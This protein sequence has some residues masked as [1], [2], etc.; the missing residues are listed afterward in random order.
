MATD[1]KPTFLQKLEEKLKVEFKSTLPTRWEVAQL[2]KRRGYCRTS[3]SVGDW[4]RI[5]E[6]FHA[7]PAIY[8]DMWHCIAML[9]LVVCGCV[10]TSN[11]TATLIAKRSR[12]SKLNSRNRSGRQLKAASVSNCERR[13]EWIRNWK[14]LVLISVRS[15]LSTY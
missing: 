11:A 13:R 3:G 6:D 1:K 15:Y 5:N 9:L 10:F 14:E 7:C 4:S 2:T 12:L 8:Q